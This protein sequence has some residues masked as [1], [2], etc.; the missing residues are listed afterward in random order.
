[1][2]NNIKNIIFTSIWILLIIIW[3]V[4]YLNS[5]SIIS[6]FILLVFIIWWFAISI[7]SI[8][9]ILSKNISMTPFKI[10]LI[11]VF[12]L[13]IIS[14]LFWALCWWFFTVMIIIEWWS[15]WYWIEY[16]SIS[17]L[18]IW[19]LLIFWW[20]FWIKKIRNNSL[21]NKVQNIKE[22]E[23]NIIDDREL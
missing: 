15:W 7:Y 16:I 18:I 14:W 23:K 6:Q 3:L 12:V 11:I 19:L 22:E 2:K 1:M 9:D 20:Y 5:F 21:K 4:F 8:K 13:I 10:F 17:S